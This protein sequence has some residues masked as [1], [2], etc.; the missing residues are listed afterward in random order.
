MY[1]TKQKIVSFHKQNVQNCIKTKQKTG[2]RSE[3]QGISPHSMPWSQVQTD[4]RQVI[5]QR[6]AVLSFSVHKYDITPYVYVSDFFQIFPFCFCFCYCCFVFWFWGAHSGP[7]MLNVHSVMSHTCTPRNSFLSLYSVCWF[8]AV[9]PVAF[10]CILWDFLCVGSCDL[11]VAMILLFLFHFTCL[12][13][14]FL[15]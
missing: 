15:A 12:L 14:V 4:V 1:C 7:H 2:C 13:S 6:T 5:K 8:A 10:L 3:Y 9:A 11:W